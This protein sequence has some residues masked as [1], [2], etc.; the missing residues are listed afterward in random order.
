MIQLLFQGQ[1]VLFIMLLGFLIISLTFHEYGHGLMARLMGDRTAEQ[2]GRLTLNPIPHI[3]PMGLLMVVFVWFGYAK[4]VPVNPANFKS[5]WGILLVSAAGPFMNLM[6]AFLSINLLGLGLKMEWPMFQGPAADI[7]LTFLAGINM[8]LAVFNMLPIG[9]LDGHYILPYF[10]PK[11]LARLYI[12]YNDRYGNW[13][14]L[15]LIVLAIMGLPIF[16]YVFAFSQYML[17]HII[18]F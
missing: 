3:D 5:S 11:N 4:P 18:V 6:L 7:F 14:L 16:Q 12:Y 17:S 8:M 1:Y 10:L 15:S 13:I 2:M 9:A